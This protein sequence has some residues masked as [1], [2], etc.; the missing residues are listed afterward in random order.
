MHPCFQVTSFGS[1]VD[2]AVVVVAE[3]ASSP[4][5]LG[6]EIVPPPGYNAPAA[7]IELYRFDAAGTF[8]SD[9]PVTFEY[10]TDVPG[11]FLF[12]RYPTGSSDPVVVTPRPCFIDRAGCFR[13]T[14]PT[15]A[16]V[17]FGAISP[18]PSPS[19]SPIMVEGDEVVSGDE[20]RSTDVTYATSGTTTIHG[21]LTHVRGHVVFSVQRNYT[22]GGMLSF[23]GGTTVTV[24]ATVTAHV[25]T[26]FQGCRL[27]ITGT[28]LSLME[29][30]PA[31]RGSCQ[32]ALRLHGRWAL[33]EVQ[34]RRCGGAGVGGW[35]ARR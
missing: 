11:D 21:T 16:F 32:S 5:L 34:G 8:V 18:S 14:S 12:H 29:V 13:I 22:G 17:A 4:Q 9:A 25:R 28:W 6:F 20:Q 3:P 30:P 35:G 19:P 10:V 15:S 27:S 24:G 7:M 26:Q 33:D 1:N 31:G 23:G 2:K